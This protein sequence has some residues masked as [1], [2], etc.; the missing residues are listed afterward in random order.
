[1]TRQEGI[2]LVAVKRRRVVMRGERTVIRPGERRVGHNG[3]M[4][5]HNSPRFRELYER[6]PRVPA[7]AA[8]PVQQIPA[9]GS[10]G[11]LAFAVISHMLYAISY[12]SSRQSVAVPTGN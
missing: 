8:P 1:M 3:S 12:Q 10:S 5:M 11:L 4:R 2:R 6:R 7:R 9:R